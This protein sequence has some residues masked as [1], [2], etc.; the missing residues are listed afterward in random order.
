[1]KEEALPP[2]EQTASAAG[3]P[4]PLK[5]KP[6]S[7][8]RRRLHKF[9]TLKR[10]Y[11]SFLVL[12]IAYAISFLL[13]VLVNNKALIVRY[14]DEYYF[15]LTRYYPASQFGVEALGEPNYRELKQKL[16]QENSGGRSCHLHDC[17][18]L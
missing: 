2:I 4:P 12:A 1:M 18:L 6:I 17:P 13:P 11:Y 3:M 5:R 16:S 14:H 8:F 7:I 15:P 10:G 9:R